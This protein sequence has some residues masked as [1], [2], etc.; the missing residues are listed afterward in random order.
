M[1]MIIAEL[2]EQSRTIRRRANL[3]LLAARKLAGADLPELSDEDGAAVAALSTAEAVL[4]EV[5]AVRPLAVSLKMAVMDNVLEYPIAS[6]WHRR[7]ARACEAS[8]DA[9]EAE[10]MIMSLHEGETSKLYL[11]VLHQ[12]QAFREGAEAH[13]ELARAADNKLGR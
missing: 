1:E 12:S 13:W 3:A 11:S 2:H 4:K 7:L 9:T 10:A 6:G 5:H 8:A